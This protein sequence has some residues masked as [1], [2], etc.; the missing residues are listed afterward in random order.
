MRV[1]WFG[2]VTALATLWCSVPDAG[3]Q[4][5][6]N[7][8]EDPETVGSGRLLF[9]AGMDWEKDAK[10]PLSG[11]TG[12]L[13][14]VPTLGVS[15]GVSSIAELQIDGGIYQRLTISEREAAPLS[16]QLEIDGEQTSAVRDLM[17]GT[18]V[19]VLS[20]QPGR[21][22]LGFRFVTRLPWTS[23]ES[24]LGRGTTDFGASFLIGK[25]I[26]SV[27]IVGNVGFVNL[28]DATEPAAHDNLL[29]YGFSLARA[30][31]EGVELVAELNGRA[32]LE[33]TLVVG[34]EDRGFVRAGARFTRGPV[35]VDGAFMLGLTPR[36]PDFGITA[37]ITWVMDAF[38]VP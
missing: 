16:S 32:N 36:D 7:I 12:N 17:I 6:P 29:T 10:Y 31:A 8:T 1:R 24:G 25:T 18:K 27:R 19:R 37:G 20:E 3:A 38:R 4:Q 21:P 30:V 28:A 34:S 5:R 11:L 22:A 15:I 26:E 33:S 9:E 14:A 2:V 35:R 23:I 13:F